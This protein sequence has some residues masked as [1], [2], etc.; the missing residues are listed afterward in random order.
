MDALEPG[1]RHYPYVAIRS[2][3]TFSY[4]IISAFNCLFEDTDRIFPVRY[5]QSDVLK[6]RAGVPAK[7]Q[8]IPR[9]T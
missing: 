2:N 9:Y 8:L 3:L 6:G 7:L 4:N 1:F 5:A